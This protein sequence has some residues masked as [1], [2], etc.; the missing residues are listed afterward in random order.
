MTDNEHLLYWI[1]KEIPA[2]LNKFTNFE[3]FDK[4]MPSACA[5]GDWKKFAYAMAK[6]R[7]GVEQIKNIPG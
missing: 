7:W 2:F 5:S 6:E 4:A 1:N 3:E